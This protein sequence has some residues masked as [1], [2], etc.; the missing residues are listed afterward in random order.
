MAKGTVFSSD[1]DEDSAV[2]DIYSIG[3]A[4]ARRNMPKDAI[5]YFD[6]VLMVDPSHTRARFNKANALGKLGKYDE[7]ILHYNS[8]IKDLPRHTHSLLN[9]G[10]ALH[11]LR[12]YDEAIACYEKTLSIEPEN[13]S[14]MYHI[15]CS[16]AVQKKNSESLS[17]LE[18]AVVLDPQ[19]AI[20][21]QKD[22]DFTGL[23]KDPRFQALV[24]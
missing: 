12:R 15:A 9:K 11:Y 18:R 21:A 17:M 5:F 22:A 14:A 20:K 13:A 7:A 2:E 16:K 4:H 23:L 19:F 1:S 3:L 24:S 6:R 10:L 8:I